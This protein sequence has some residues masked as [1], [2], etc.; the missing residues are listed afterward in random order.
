MTINKSGSSAEYHKS[1]SFRN[2]YSHYYLSNIDLKFRLKNDYL[3]YINRLRLNYCHHMYY[4]EY[5]IKRKN[6]VDK[7]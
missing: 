2:G 5:W 7:Q 4:T 6:D 3:I 1:S